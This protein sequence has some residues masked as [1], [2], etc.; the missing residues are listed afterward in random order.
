MKTVISLVLA[1]SFAI[2]A[3]QSLAAESSPSSEM[4]DQGGGVLKQV[5]TGL[6]WTQSD[7]GADINWNT[8]GAFC[9]AKG[10]GWRL[11]SVAELQSLHDES[12][13]SESRCGTG[14]YLQA[15]PLF[16]LTGPWAWTN[17]ASNAMSTWIVILTKGN[18]STYVN[19]DASKKRALCVLGS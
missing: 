17:E 1:G 4:V 3:C 13:Q 12:G 10:A 6:E 14:F 16:H 5:A 7:N 18:A 9:A 8:A 19:S 2:N 15:S 11:P